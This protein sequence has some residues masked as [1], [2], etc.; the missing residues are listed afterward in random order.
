MSA[1]ISASNPTRAASARVSAPV[2]VYHLPVRLWH[3]VTVFAIVTLSVTGFLI[4]DPPWPVLLGQPSNLFLMGD[5]RVTHFIAGDVLAV[6]LLVR[7]YWAVVGNRYER[8][9]FMPAIWRGRWW[10]GLLRT[11]RWYLFLERETP[12]EIGHNPLEQIAMFVMFT[13]GVLFEI[14]TGFAL[15][16]Q[17][18]GYGTWAYELFTSWVVPLFGNGQILHTWH[19]LG[20]WYL[21][22]FSMVH[23]YM[24]IRED[25]MARYSV[26]STMF[27]GWRFFKDDRD[28]GESE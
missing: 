8:E 25:I 6:A 12:R 20:M 11:I 4:A 3:W 26:M 17:G 9:I 10:R 13:L 2:Y 15:Y 7:M 14:V 28:E 19:H 5:I 1:H 18:T 22:V 27:S 23:V 21:I 24:T 16:G